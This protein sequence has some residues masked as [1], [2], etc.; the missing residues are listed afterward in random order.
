MFDKILTWFWTIIAAFSP[1]AEEKQPQYYE[2]NKLCVAEETTQI[3]YITNL[4]AT[5][6]QVQHIF[7][8]GADA[9]VVDLSTGKEF[10]IRRSFGTHHADV[11]PLTTT[12]TEIM[13][14]IW[15]GYS[16]ARR[17][18]AIYVAGQIFPA[19]LTFSPHA[20]RD[21]M[22]A[23]ATVDARSGGYGR[24][25]NM[26]TIKGNGIN[27]IICL[28]FEGSLLHGSLRSNPD[29]Q[30]AVARAREILRNLNGGEAQSP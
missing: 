2:E 20:G 7:P 15:G 1:D 5:W 3:Q 24:G 18:V 6:E 26:D 4:Y 21:D 27:G 25:V 29:H 13:R 14:N 10:N 16:W 22:P 17:P 8:R 28:H 30:N 9:R 12:D 19:S 11:E 23:L